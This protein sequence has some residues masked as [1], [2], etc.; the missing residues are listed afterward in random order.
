MMWCFFFKTMIPVTT[1]T[2]T[3]QPL[4]LLASWDSLERRGQTTQRAAQMR[5]AIAA[6]YDLVWWKVCGSLICRFW[7]LIFILVI[8]H[9]L[10]SFFL[11]H[12]FYQKPC[13]G[14]SGNLK[15]SVDSQGATCATMIVETP[16]SCKG[17]CT[18]ES[19]V[20]LLLSLFMELN[21]WFHVTCNDR[22][23]RLWRKVLEGFFRFA[24]TLMKRCLKSLSNPASRS[25]VASAVLFVLWSIAA[26]MW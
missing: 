23:W 12:F 11:E 2:E 14:C 26:A 24:N 6:W 9:F 7:K 13:T 19:I 18:S 17:M 1:K 3:F 5:A 10:W 16:F 4:F 25:Q 22:P 21:F 8:E 15:A 20:E